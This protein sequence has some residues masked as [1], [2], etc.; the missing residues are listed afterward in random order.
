MFNYIMNNKTAIDL[1]IK[2]YLV[3]S[4]LKSSSTHPRRQTLNSNNQPQT[5]TNSEEQI[6]HPIEGTATQTKLNIAPKDPLLY[7]LD[8]FLDFLGFIV[9]FRNKGLE[10]SFRVFF[11]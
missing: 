8:G 1:L 9:H 7:I 6:A 3:P 5:S 10:I 11:V 2:S 4:K